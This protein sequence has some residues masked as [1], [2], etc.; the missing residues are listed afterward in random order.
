MILLYEYHNILL[1]NIIEIIIQLLYYVIIQYY[2][3]QLLHYIIIQYYIIQLLY[4][5]IIQYYW[6]RNIMH[7]SDSVESANKEIALWFTEQEL[8]SWE[9][10]SNTW[11]YGAN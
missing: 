7:G 4:Y 8:V 11:V 2:I 6:Y 3:T 1:F 5:I 9:P 10:V